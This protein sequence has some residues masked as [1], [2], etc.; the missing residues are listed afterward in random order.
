MSTQTSSQKY[1][2][3][4]EHLLYMNKSSLSRELA[5]KQA[6]LH[7]EKVRSKYKNLAKFEKIINADIV[8]IQNE[9]DKRLTEEQDRT[10]IAMSKVVIISS[11]K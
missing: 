9:L 5:F 1:K 7:D 6:R 4:T 3:L 11:D 10:K 2:K 8:A